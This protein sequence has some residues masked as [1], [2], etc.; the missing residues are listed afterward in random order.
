[1]FHFPTQRFP[2]FLRKRNDSVIG[3]PQKTVSRGWYRHGNS[4][5]KTEEE[6]D[7]RGQDKLKMKWKR[8]QFCEWRSIRLDP[9][10]RCA[11]WWCV[12]MAMGLYMVNGFTECRPSV[13]RSNESP[14]HH[15]AIKPGENWDLVLNAWHWNELSFPLRLKSTLSYINLC[16]RCYAHKK[17]SIVL[18]INH[19]DFSFTHI[20]HGFQPKLSL[21]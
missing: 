2:S 9:D 4:W 14:D 8:Y 17:G 12:P 19:F 10:V 15:Q 3:H 21:A 16:K 20:P 5:V 13:M 11:N 18:L 1:M 7:G 6:T